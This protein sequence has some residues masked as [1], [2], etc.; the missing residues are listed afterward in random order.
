[1]LSGERELYAFDGELIE[2]QVFDGDLQSSNEFDG[3]YGDYMPVSHQDVYEGETEITPSEEDQILQ[4]DGKMVPTNI[5]IHAIP[6][7]YGLITW[8]GH[9]LTV[10]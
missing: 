1:M 4:T 3:E 10:S 8:D 7:N 9:K 5:T 2:A 6:S